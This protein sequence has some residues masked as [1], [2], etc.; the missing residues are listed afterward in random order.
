M[1]CTCRIDRAVGCGPEIQKCPLC[2]SAPRLYGALKN[3]LEY[4]DQHEWGT[5]PSGGITDIEARE[6]IAEAEKQ[7]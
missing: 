1:K 5:V 2:K 7:S 3:L 6:A 4:L